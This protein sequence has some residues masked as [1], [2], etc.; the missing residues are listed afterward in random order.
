MNRLLIKLL[1]PVLAL[2]PISLNGQ[3]FSDEEIQQRSTRTERIDVGGYKLHFRVTDGVLPAIVFESGGGLDSTEWRAVQ[4]LVRINLNNAAVS[5]SRSG[6]GQSARSQSDLSPEP[7]DI[8][9]EVRALRSG[10]NTLGLADNINYVGHSYGAF[11][12]DVYTDLYPDPILGLLYVEPN[13]IE[14]VNATGGPE[15]IL[16]EFE[17]DNLPNSDYAIAIAKQTLAS[18]E[19]FDRVSAIQAADRNCLVIT[20]GI[21]WF[22]NEEQNEIWR[23]A[24][25]HLAESCGTELIV[26]EG[27]NHAVP[28]LSPHL[29]L[30]KVQEL[31]RH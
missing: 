15:K 21:K 3:Q 11:L 23:T 24:H 25:E 20:A 19:V 4:E 30:D 6:M 14:Y 5:Y 27:D 22:D 7:Y 26:A 13:S 28:F 2:Y 16:N 18:K 10:L 29:I 9:T 8:E 12:L 31:L 1:A 17:S